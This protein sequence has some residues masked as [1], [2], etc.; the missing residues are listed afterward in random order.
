MSFRDVVCVYENLEKNLPFYDFHQLQ[1]Q[2]DSVVLILEGRASKMPKSV[3]FG[4][5]LF[6]LHL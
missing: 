3:S 6:I 4:V 1:T 5:S 2:S